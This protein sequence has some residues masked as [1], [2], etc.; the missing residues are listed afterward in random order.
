MGLDTK[1]TNDLFYLCCMAKIN[2]AQDNRLTTEMVS[3][4]HVHMKHNYLLS[5]DPRLLESF[6]HRRG[7]IGTNNEERLI[8]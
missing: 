4:I 6:N 3:Y 5:P 7:T 2:T 8:D 1:Q